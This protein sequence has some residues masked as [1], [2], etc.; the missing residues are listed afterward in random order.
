MLMLSP[1]FSLPELTVTQQTGPDG[2]ILPNHPG[3]VELLYLRYLCNGLLEPIRSLW[4]CPV[5]VTSGYRCAQV[6]MKVSGTLNS[7]HLHGQAADIHPLSDRLTIHDAYNI[8]F[9]SWLPYDQLLLEGTPGHQWIHVST[10]PVV[11]E[12]R[13]QA[14]VSLDGHN[15]TPYNPLEVTT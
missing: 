1:N 10:A 5:G 14:L 11:S 15:F 13:R 2:K 9:L 6:E 7:Q 4:G 3:E 12:P 8:I